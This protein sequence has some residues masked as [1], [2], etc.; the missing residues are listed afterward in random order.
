[1]TTLP[2]EID[3]LILGGLVH[4]ARPFLCFLIG[5]DKDAAWK[6]P[7]IRHVRI[8]DKFL[9]ASSAST[10]YID[11]DTLEVLKDPRVEYRQINLNVA[12]NIAAIYES[13]HGGSYH[14]VF[15]LTGDG[16]LPIIL[17]E[18]LLLERTTKLAHA[19][20]LESKRR[21][22]RAHIRYTHCFTTVS[23]DAPP[24]KEGDVVKPKTPRAYWWYEA[25]RA[26]ACIQ[27]LN[28]AILRPAQLMGPHLYDSPATARLLIGKLYQFKKEP[29]KWLWGPELRIHTLW[30]VDCCRAAW[31]VA[32]WTAERDRATSDQ[33]AG[34][35]LPPVQMKDKA[36]AALRESV[37]EGCCPRNVTPTAPVF[38]IVDDGDMTHLCRNFSPSFSSLIARCRPCYATFALMRTDRGKFIEM[39]GDFYKIEVGFVNAAINAWAKLN[40]LSVVDEVNERHA[41]WVEDILQVTQRRDTPLTSFQDPDALAYRAVALDNSKIKRV[42]GWQPAVKIDKERFKE[43]AEVW[44]K[45]GLWCKSLEARLG[46]KER[47]DK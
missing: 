37:G 10:T 45:S 18:E 40:L 19:L 34:E 14:F 32:L 7:K 13:P 28:L 2:A 12:A 16:V 44:L 43:L 21:N 33:E 17:P 20:A 11:P 47:D 3:V 31:E 27:G 23:S 36:K 42:V 4:L 6:G 8:A 41:A 46:L 26:A 9:V 39:L 38:N 29:M 15:D 25:E 35:K 1:M 5:A 30:S 24:A 22:V